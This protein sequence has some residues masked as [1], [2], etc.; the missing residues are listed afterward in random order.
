MKLVSLS[1]GRTQARP[2]VFEDKVVRR[3]LGPKSGR[4]INDWIKWVS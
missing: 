1:N 4:V 3:A 2:V